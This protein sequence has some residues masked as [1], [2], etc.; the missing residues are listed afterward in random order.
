MNYYIFP[1]A[2]SQ[3]HIESKYIFTLQNKKGNGYPFGYPF[4]LAREAGLEFQFCGIYGIWETFICNKYRFCIK[5][6]II[7]NWIFYPYPVKGYGKGKNKGNKAPGKQMTFTG[8]FYISD[9][10][11]AC[12]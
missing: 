12:R 10:T 4:P 6:S 11:D 8:C 3:P 5:Y 2:P 7:S 1:V 9:G